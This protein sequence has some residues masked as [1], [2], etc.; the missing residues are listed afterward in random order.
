MSRVDFGKFINDW[1]VLFSVSY[2]L[3]DRTGI[4][5][6]TERSKVA[7][8]G[9]VQGQIDRRY[10]EELG[11]R[12]GMGREKSSCGPWVDQ[13]STGDQVRVCLSK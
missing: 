4:L 1:I 10:L 11:L 9:R 7:W 13:I 5:A 8:P 3:W 6:T 12:A 2:R